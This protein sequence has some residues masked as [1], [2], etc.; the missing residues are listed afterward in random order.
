MY[1]DREKTP[2]TAEYLGKDFKFTKTRMTVGDYTIHGKKTVF[3]VERKNSWDE[4]ASAVLTKAGRETLTRQ[5]KSLTKFKKRVLIV[6]D[7]WHR[8]KTANF[9][10]DRRINGQGILN[11]L[12][13]LLIESNV[14]I[15]TAG[16][17]G[18]SVV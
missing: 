2:W 12:M 4:I 11:V 1:D 15:F 10:Q 8:L 14:P 16:R 7:T 5:I 17:R 9:I 3:R 6:E 18:K 13:P